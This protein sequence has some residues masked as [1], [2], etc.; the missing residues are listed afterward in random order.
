MIRDRFIPTVVVAVLGEDTDRGNG[1]KMDIERRTYHSLGSDMTIYLYVTG[2]RVA[3]FTSACP[4]NCGELSWKVVLRLG[5]NLYG[6]K[7]VSVTKL[8]GFE[9]CPSDNCVIM[10]LVTNGVARDGCLC[11]RDDIC[12]VVTRQGVSVLVET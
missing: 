6:K 9:Q 2:T 10:R 4:R 3:C 7:L 8:L 1:Y 5:R 11:P 12:P